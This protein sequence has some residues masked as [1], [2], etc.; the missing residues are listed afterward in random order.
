M[1]GGVIETAENVRR[2]YGIGREE[3][4]RYALLSH[5]RA[6][7]AWDA[8]KF[9]EET[10]PVPL[11]SRIGDTLFDRDEHPRADTSLDKLLQ[12][13]PVMAQQDAEATVT[14]GN[15]SGQN[16]AAACCI[17]TSPEKA[18]ALGLKP[19]AK[20]RGWAAVGVHPAYMGMGPVP[21]VNRLLERL[22]LKLHDIDL[23]E[24]NEAFAV[25]VLACLR[26]WSLDEDDIERV[27]VNGS[28]ISIG[29]PVGA[30]GGRI[31]ATLL[32]EMERRN[33]QFGLE[34]MCIGGGQGIAAVVE[35]VA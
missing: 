24:L 28:G 20:F 26:E 29:H 15:A 14:A 27:N 5:Q 12:L 32:H 17:V 30:T 9:A 23:I 2:K 11:K 25:Q 1:P 31:M 8:G 13:R 10:V 16:D 22:D 7:A 18:A 6:V 33:A 35:R 19:M 21:A 4:D 3:Q 34:T